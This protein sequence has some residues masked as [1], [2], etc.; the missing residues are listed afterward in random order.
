MKNF[1]QNASLFMFFGISIIVVLF[2]FNRVGKEHENKVEHKETEYHPPLYRYDSI[3]TGT[4]RF[5]PIT[6]KKG[7]EITE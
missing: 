5:D 7:V 6:K 4:L 3:S 1:N 2:V